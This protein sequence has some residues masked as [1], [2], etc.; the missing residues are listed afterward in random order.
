MDRN[1]LGKDGKGEVTFQ[2]KDRKTVKAQKVN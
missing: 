1:L 2:E